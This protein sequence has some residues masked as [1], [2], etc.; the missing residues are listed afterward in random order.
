MHARQATYMSIPVASGWVLFLAALPW[1]LRLSELSC[2]CHLAGVLAKRLHQEPE[3]LLIHGTT[4][5]LVD[6]EEE[7]ARPVELLVTE[8]LVLDNDVCL[9]FRRRGLSSDADLLGFAPGASEGC[10]GHRPR[11]P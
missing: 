10:G 3:L 2:A 1:L 8:A 7:L 5:V 6:R 11:R 4:V 9:P